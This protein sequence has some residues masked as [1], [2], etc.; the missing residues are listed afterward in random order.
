MAS[1][2]AE[3]V[4]EIKQPPAVNF[5]PRDYEEKISVEPDIGDQRQSV[6]KAL[7]NRPT[8]PK[9]V[10]HKFRFSAVFAFASAVVA[11]SLKLV[12]VLAGQE[13]GGM[14]QGDYMIAVGDVDCFSIAA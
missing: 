9:R 14:L 1:Y 13:P 2:Y 6:Y 10:M 12:F 7:P 5:D 4:G 3:T 11:F 8:T